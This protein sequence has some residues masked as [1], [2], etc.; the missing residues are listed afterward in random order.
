MYYRKKEK[1]LWREISPSRKVIYWANEE[2][3]LPVEDDDVIQWWGVSK[4]ADRLAGKKNEVI[5]S[6]YDQAYLD[7]GFG[8]RYGDQ[9]PGYI[10]E[11]DMYKFNPMVKDVNVIGGETCMWS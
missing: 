3:N 9:R 6:F 4:N 8:G 5:L 2:I 10:S 1:Q 11:R 7:L